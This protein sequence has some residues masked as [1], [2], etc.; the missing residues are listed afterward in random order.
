MNQAKWDNVARDYA[1]NTLM[2]ANG[3]SEWNAQA[4]RE[5]DL[6]R[7]LLP[8]NVQTLVEIGCGIGRLTRYL[9]ITF[10]NVIATDT[11]SECRKVT[12]AATLRRRVVVDEGLYPP[13]DAALVWGGLYDDDWRNEAMNVHFNG[14]VAMYPMV[15]YGTRSGRHPTVSALDQAGV[16]VTGEDDATGTQWSLWN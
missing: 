2:P 13:G 5:A 7:S 11:S 12:R 16:I 14:I 10:P 9:S 15:L 1:A 4:R 6:I 8:E 3:W